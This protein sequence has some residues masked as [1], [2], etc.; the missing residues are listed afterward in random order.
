[1]IRQEKLAHIIQTLQ[2]TQLPKVEQDVFH[3][4][5]RSPDAAL[6]DCLRIPRSR[7]WLQLLPRSSGHEDH[8]LHVRFMQILYGR[9]ARISPDRQLFLLA[10]FGFPSSLL[11][12]LSH[13]YEIIFPP[14]ALFFPSL[15]LN[16]HGKRGIL[17]QMPIP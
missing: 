1:M 15:P 16:P 10:L 12:Q 17:P 3:S 6:F 9:E 14:S 5:S 7:Y 2:P 4:I 8:P 11:S 13:H